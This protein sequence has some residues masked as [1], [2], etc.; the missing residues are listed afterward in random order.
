MKFLLSFEP[1][2]ATAGSQIAKEHPEWL[3]TAVDAGWTYGGVEGGKFNL[4][5][6]KARAWMTDLLSQRITEYG[7]DIYRQDNNAPAVKF[8]RANDPVDRQGITEIRH[9][10]GLYAMWDALHRRHP[11][12]LIDN[13]NWRGTGP[14]LEVTCRSSGSFSRSECGACGQ[15]SLANQVA[16]AGLSLYVP[17]HGNG[18]WALT[19]YFLRSVCTT[20]GDGGLTWQKPIAG[21][22]HGLAGQEPVAR[23]ANEW[24]S[25]Q[26]PIARQAIAE[27]RLLRPLCLGDYYPLTAID[28]SEKSWC[29]AVRSAR[30]GRGSCG[31]LSPAQVPEFRPPSC[32]AGVR[33]LG[34]IRSGLPRNVR[35]PPDK[36]ND[37]PGSS[38]LR[39]DFGRPGRKPAGPL[40]AGKRLKAMAGRGGGPWLLL[41]LASL[42]DCQCPGSLK[43]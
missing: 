8:W 43:C 7:V 38:K 32:L 14:D 34:Q 16:T 9:V 21:Q 10:E 5:D 23:E 17:I 41:V 27:I 42:G 33:C 1:E 13:A 2:R 6:P 25:W 24:L 30:L 29:L 31:F 3:L 26:E 35:Y 11:R 28:T 19:P 39:V 22:A 37:R 36:E 12:L 18:L 20:G 40:P 4:G 15:N